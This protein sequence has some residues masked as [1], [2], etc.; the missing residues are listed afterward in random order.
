MKR[1][2]RYTAAFALLLLPLLWVGCMEDMSDERA[3]LPSSSTTITIP[4]D[5]EIS[6]A[7]F[8]ALNLDYPGLESVK[9]HYEAGS[10]YQAAY[11]LLEYFRSRT[12]VEHPDINLMSP[13]ISE[14]QQKQA[15]W[16]LSA[17]NYRFYIAGYTDPGGKDGAPYSWMKD[18]AVDWTLCPSGDE[19]QR[20]GV[21]RHAWYLPQALA[22]R[23]SQNETY[24]KEWVAVHGDWI[25]KHPLSAQPLD[26]G[27]QAP[28]INSNDYAWRVDEV[29]DR[30]VD[31]SAVMLY[32]MQSVNF[33][34]AWAATFLSSLYEQ[35]AWLQGYLF[36][37]EC[38]ETEARRKEMAY[39][40]NKVL[41]LFPE[42]KNTAAWREQAV[43]LM[44]DGIDPALF[45]VL[46]LD[47][48]ALASVK[49]AYEAEDYY[50]AASEVLNYYRQR[51][52]VNNPNVNKALTAATA[53]E[54]L[55]A[56]YALRENEYRFY[57]KNY[58]EDV[59]AKKPYS[60]MAEDGSIDWQTMPT[61]EQENR[62]QLHRHMWMVPQAKVFYTTRDEKYVQ[63]WMEVFLDWF[64]QNPRPT[65]DIDFSTWPGNLPAELQ[66]Y[67]WTW[68]SLDVAA[69]LIDHC[70]VLEYVKDAESITPAFWLQFLNHIASE[71]DHITENYSADSNHLITQAQAVAQSGVLLPELKRAEAWV[72]SGSSVLIDC[73][74]SQY[75]ADG[76]LKDGDFQYH[77]SSIEDF[78]SAMHFA[79]V[80]GR[81]DIYPDTYR[82]A[83]RKMTEVVMHM[84]YPDYSSVN[85]ADTQKSSWTKSV[86][87]KNLNRY[88]ELFP[89]NQELLWLATEGK[90]GTQP[91]ATSKGFS[92][93]GYYVLRSGWTK[94]DLMM[95]VG[96]TTQSPKQQWHCQ[97][98]NGTFEL[99]V[100]G[101]HFFPDSGSNSYGG[102]SESNARRTKYAATAAHNT[103]TLNG[104]NIT[105]G[106]GEML[107]LDYNKSNKCDRL[108]IKNPSYEG[109]THRRSI[110]L[111]EGKFYVVVDE[112]Y[113]AAAG[114]V[115]LNFHP[116]E[117]EENITLD[118]EAMGMHTTFTDGNNLLVR[119]FT[120]AGAMTFREREGFYSPKINVEI[121]RK[122]YAL[123]VEKEAD[124]PV[125]FITV[126]YPATDA[127]TPQIKAQ[128]SGDWT[129]AR[130]AV[131]VTIDGTEYSLVNTSLTE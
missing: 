123:D 39:N 16:A 29:A 79:Q 93:C 36:S 18:K 44:N 115:N 64:K 131:K 20:Y 55:Y 10:N 5:S 52:N 81:N 108:V 86:L 51:S 95:V 34:P 61:S 37:E 8:E 4:D 2:L 25:S 84:I 50:T 112:A 69:R 11:A 87:K 94:D 23:T 99:Y 82:E 49:A 54:Q 19:A 65:M 14:E 105:Q 118:S 48:P 89:E 120:D 74:E 117:S 33:T 43:A 73:V 127:T 97:W 114:T 30:V 1:Y 12:E 68:R 91:T 31:Y 98:D 129:A 107:R 9:A 76:W 125:R 28:A 77:I 32:T 17:N 60:Y 116:G 119:S 53:D 59:E 106:A 24:V 66:N 88:V 70:T 71:A 35:T 96:N 85:M 113:G 38:P 57:V 121:K 58:Y 26:E 110:F 22:Y 3:S 80:N 104:E 92:D 56:N 13:S 45:G 47:Y 40:L 128:F 111:V 130:C 126:L 7:I 72:E 100:K 41:A 63:G 75:F 109:L 101:R 124:K 62:Y 103:L 46:N 21:H 27:D 67:G 102:S 83:L 6:T 42:F 90:E 78:R 15:D 122:A